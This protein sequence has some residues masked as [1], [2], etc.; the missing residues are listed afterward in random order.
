MTTFA[1][2][3][4]DAAGQ[5]AGLASNCAEVHAFCSVVNLDGSCFGRSTF[6][7]RCSTASWPGSHQRA[8]RIYDLRGQAR[9]LR[10]TAFPAVET[11]KF[12]ANFKLWHDPIWKGAP[13]RRLRAFIAIRGPR[14]R[15]RATVR[16]VEHE[17]GPVD[18]RVDRTDIRRDPVEDRRDRM[19]TRRVGRDRDLRRMRIHF[20]PRTHHIRPQVERARHD[21]RHD[22][23]A[24]RR[25]VIRARQIDRGRRR[26]C[27]GINNGYGPGPAPTTVCPICDAAEQVPRWPAASPH[28]GTEAIIPTAPRAP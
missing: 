23:Q 27:C 21:R 3:T 13:D 20:D 14:K 17:P 18:D 26:F 4:T 28:S 7:E 12:G 19:R 24:E 1:R 5:P 2:P 16:R 15:L 9:T 10:F 8:R 22:R 25:T 11:L 6:T